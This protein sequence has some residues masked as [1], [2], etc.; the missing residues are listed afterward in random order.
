M[1]YQILFILVL[2]GVPIYIVG[3]TKLAVGIHQVNPCIIAVRWMSSHGVSVSCIVVCA[4]CIYC[5]GAESSVSSF[6]EAVVVATDSDVSSD[7]AIMESISAR[8]SSRVPVAAS[9]KLTLVWRHI[10]VQKR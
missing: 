9:E 10:S 4:G 6:H 1:L 2:T 3:V 7:S 5:V 8:A